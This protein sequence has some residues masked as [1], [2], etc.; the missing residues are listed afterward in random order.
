MV[1][2]IGGFPS[3][4]TFRTRFERINP[5]RAI[6][7]AQKVSGDGGMMLNLCGEAFTGHHNGYLNHRT[8]WL[9]PSLESRDGR[10]DL[11]SV[12]GASISTS[13]S[14]DTV[15]KRNGP[16][17]IL[18]LAVGNV[19][20]TGRP[21]AIFVADAATAACGSSLWAKIITTVP[22]MSCFVILGT[23]ARPSKLR[24]YR[25]FLSID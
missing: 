22:N 2:D 14:S 9:V 24:T 1:E 20:A 12:V 16:R 4:S 6:N 5:S 10:L 17:S 25:K 21:W 18:G 15:G 23:I 7:L 11:T 13:W 8:S 19:A 3:K